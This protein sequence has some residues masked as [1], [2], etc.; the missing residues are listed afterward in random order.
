MFCA[1]QRVQRA[2][3]TIYNSQIIVRINKCRKKD[4]PAPFKHYFGIT[5]CDDYKLS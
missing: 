5:S 1:T 2:T 4:F 3:E